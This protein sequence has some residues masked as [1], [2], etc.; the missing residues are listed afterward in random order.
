MSD[1]HD[2]FGI[3][4]EMAEVTNDD[5]FAILEELNSLK[6]EL[7]ENLR[8]TRFK[9]NPD[10][11]TEL[12]ESILEMYGED[13]VSKNGYYVTFDMFIQMLDVTKL[14]SADKADQLLGKY[15]I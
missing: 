15:A 13:F 7:Y 12:H 9:Y 1:S 14:A 3:S 10:V 2:Q 4:D 11:D 8:H 6:K 5:L